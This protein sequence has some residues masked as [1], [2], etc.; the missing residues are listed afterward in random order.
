MKFFIINCNLY[1]NTKH[2]ILQ[3]LMMLSGCVR[4]NLVFQVL[5]AKLIKTYR[6]LMALLNRG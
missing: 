1:L 2:E 3:R 6:K 4:I 5:G